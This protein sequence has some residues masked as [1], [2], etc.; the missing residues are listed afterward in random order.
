MAVPLVPMEEWQ[1]ILE[2][3]GNNNDGLLSFRQPHITASEVQVSR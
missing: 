1:T 3:S 2:Q